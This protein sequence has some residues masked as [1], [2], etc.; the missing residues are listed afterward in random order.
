MHISTFSEMDSERGYVKTDCLVLIHYKFL[1]ISGRKKH[2]QHVT[3]HDK[4]SY[5][6]WLIPDDFIVATEYRENAENLW[7]FCT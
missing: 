3:A 4:I 5:A 2:Y 1:I 6:S 7:S